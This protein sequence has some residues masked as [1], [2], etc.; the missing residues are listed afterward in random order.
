MDNITKKKAIVKLSL[1]SSI[2]RER[3]ESSTLT[4]F[5]QTPLFIYVITKFT[6]QSICQTE[7]RAKEPTPAENVDLAEKLSDLK[8]LEQVENIPLIITLI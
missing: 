4:T 5:A 6:A 7:Q 3:R 1:T 8:P 2:Y